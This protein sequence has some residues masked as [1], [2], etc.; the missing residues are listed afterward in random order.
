LLETFTLRIL[1]KGAQADLYLG[2][3]DDLFVAENVEVGA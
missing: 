3:N 2:A 1:E